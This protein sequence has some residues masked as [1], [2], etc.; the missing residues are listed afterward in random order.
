VLA[1]TGLGLEST[2]ATGAGGETLE[3]SIDRIPFVGPTMTG[4]KSRQ[5][6]KNR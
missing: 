4:F 1:C 5:D 3:T 6:E 2:G